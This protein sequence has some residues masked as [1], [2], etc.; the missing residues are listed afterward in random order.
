MCN[1]LIYLCELC[2]LAARCLI[3]FEMNEVLQLIQ[4]ET[5]ILKEIRKK[6]MP[7]VMCLLLSHNEIMYVAS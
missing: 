5:M 1:V 4:Q 2:A 6:F 7:F 3:M